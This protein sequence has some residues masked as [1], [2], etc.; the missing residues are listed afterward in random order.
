MSAAGR[1]G[2]G[3]AWSTIDQGVVS[4]TNFVFGLVVGRML[5]PREFGTFGLAFV[6]WLLIQGVGRALVTQPYLIKNA[7]G[8]DDDAAW[9]SYAIA[10]G[11]AACAVLGVAGAVVWTTV[12]GSVGSVVAALAL[13]APFL[14]L[15]D[16]ARLTLVKKGLYRSAISNDAAVGLAQ[17]TGVTLYLLAGRSVGVVVILFGAGAAAGWLLLIVRGHAAPAFS[18]RAIHAARQ[19]RDAGAAWLTGQFAVYWSYSYLSLALVAIVLGSASTGGLRSVQMLFGFVP[20]IVL[21]FENFALPHFAREY[22]AGREVGLRDELARTGL[23]VVAVMM[24]GVVLI[25]SLGGWALVTW[26]GADYA[27]FAPLAK[28]LAVQYAFTVLSAPLIVGLKASGGARW[29]F[30]ARV[31]SLVVVVATL[32]LL[33]PRAGIAGA[34]WAAVASEAASFAIVAAATAITQRRPRAAVAPADLVEAQPVNKG[35]TLNEKARPVNAEV[36]P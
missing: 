2:A 16:F 12:G 8:R 29:T 13:A 32:L 1:R 28:I 34:G 26:F 23:P 6:G 3:V 5:G 30:T 36:R 27:R 9:T 14:F 33:V 15:Q 7:D 4:G 11:C 17:V 19:A 25:G 24:A 21:G 35:S 20:V 31:T 10:Y 22:A 18:R